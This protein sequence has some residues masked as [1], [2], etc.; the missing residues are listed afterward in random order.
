MSRNERRMNNDDF[1]LLKGFD[2]E[3]TNRLTDGHL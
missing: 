2:D 3:W 1:K